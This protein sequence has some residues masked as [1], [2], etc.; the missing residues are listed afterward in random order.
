MFSIVCRVT[1]QVS[2]FCFNH[3]P[4][5]HWR[6]I[7]SN[8]NSTEGLIQA[9]L[10]ITSNCLPLSPLVCH[11]NFLEGNVEKK[12]QHQGIRGISDVWFL[13][14]APRGTVVSPEYKRQ[15]HHKHA[16]AY[17]ELTKAARAVSDITYAMLP[18]SQTRH[19]LSQLSHR[20]RK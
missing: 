14:K 19:C 11:S 9:M 1:T 8:E 13:P 5:A 18:P 4:T 16:A 20:N 3:I 10:S 7:I 17:L 15:R 12:S 2:H 6:W